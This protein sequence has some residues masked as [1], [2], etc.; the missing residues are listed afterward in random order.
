MYATETGNAQQ[1]A[2]KLR[3][4]LALNLSNVFLESIENCPEDWTDFDI[5]LFIVSTTGEGEVPRTMKE[6]WRRL[7]SVPTDPSILS[8]SPRVGIF[9][10]GDSSYEKVSF[11]LNLPSGHVN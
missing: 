5:V 8:D 7:L 1:L 2:E 9:G 6:F 3:Y 10:L 4:R 11:F